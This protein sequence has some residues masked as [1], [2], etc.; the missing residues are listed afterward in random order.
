MPV[1]TTGRRLLTRRYR[2]AQVLSHL[3]ECAPA[4]ANGD[5]NIEGVGT[6][7]DNVGGLDIDISSSADGNRPRDGQDIL[8][9]PSSE[10][11]Q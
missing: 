11:G 1:E 10:Q 5:G 9:C 7:H 3:A 8:V 6:H 4:D 2:P